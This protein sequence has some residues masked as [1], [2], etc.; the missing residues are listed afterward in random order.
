MAKNLYE[1]MA[2]DPIFKGILDISDLS[3]NKDVPSDTKKPTNSEGRERRNNKFDG[4]LSRVGEGPYISKVNNLIDGFD[5]I[6]DVLK[7][8]ESELALST[9][10][11][12]YEINGDQS[13]E[14]I[15]DMTYLYYMGDKSIDFNSLILGSNVN[16]ISYLKNGKVFLLFTDKMPVNY[17]GG[18]DGRRAKVSKLYSPFIKKVRQAVKM[19]N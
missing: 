2:D 8:A 6:R 17:E 13:P 15:V 4:K 7:E 1:S 16:E 9:T 5:N 14:G 10:R 12:K 19:S 18:E 11:L 3:D